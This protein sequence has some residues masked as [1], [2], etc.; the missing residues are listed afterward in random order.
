QVTPTWFSDHRLLTVSFGVEDPRFQAG[1][2]KLNKQ[3]LHEERYRRKIEA[4]LKNLEKRRELFSSA[5]HWWESC[6]Q[7]LAMVTRRYCWIRR[8]L[9]E[10]QCAQLQ[11]ELEALYEQLNQGGA[12]NGEK[13]A[14]VRSLLREKWLQRAKNFLFRLRGVWKEGEEQCSPQFFS[15]ERKQQERCCFESIRREDGTAVTDLPGML[16]CATGFYT[17]LFQEKEID[18]SIKERLLEGVEKAVDDPA[19]L[20]GPVTGAEIKTAL[21]GLKK[22]TV[23]GVDG[24]PAEFY[25]TF[26]DQLEPFLVQVF[27]EALDSNELINSFV[28]IPG[29]VLVVDGQIGRDSLRLIN[30]YAP[31]QRRLRKDFFTVLEPLLMTNKKIILGDWWED[32]KRRLK[33]ETIRYCRRRRKKKRL[34]NFSF[35]CSEGNLSCLFKMVRKDQK[36]MVFDGIQRKDGGVTMGAREMVEEAT[37][38]YKEFFREEPVSALLYVIYLEPLLEMI[39]KH[40]EINGI[41]IP[42]S[43]G[44]QAKLA[45]YA[46]D[47]VLMLD[48]D[49]GLLRAIEACNSFGQVT[50]AKI[51]TTKSKMKYFGIWKTRKETIGGLT[52]VPGP[53]KILGVNFAIRGSGHLNWKE[54][55]NFLKIKLGRWKNVQLSYSSKIMVVKSD[56]LSAL[57]FLAYVFPLPPSLRKEVIRSVFTF[58]W[59]NKNEYIRRVDMYRKIEEGGRDVPNIPLKLDAI[60]VSCLCRALKTDVMHKSQYF[61]RLWFSWTMPRLR[62]ISNTGPKADVTPWY[63]NH[64][65]KWL[66]NHPEGKD[67]IFVIQQ[68]ALY[69]LVNEQPGMAL[70]GK[71]KENW[72]RVQPKELDYSYKD[73]N[74]L[75][76]WNRLPVREVMFRHKLTKTKHCPYSECEETETIKHVF[77]ECVTAKQVWDKCQQFL[78]CIQPGFL[79]TSEKVTFAWK[80]TERKGTVDWVLWLVISIIKHFL[81]SA[82]CA[83]IR[84]GMK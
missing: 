73:L 15:A 19:S 80:G 27:N 12:F 79:L 60:F 72:I 31:A 26:W 24:L 18:A 58:I 1:Y 61:V 66:K 45:A 25:R 74:W 70:I 49:M 84:D 46:D 39:R 9:E 16:E 7:T 4:A 77:W 10:R 35:D 23:P 36:K 57:V 34:K 52:L 38:F 68:K 76:V 78:T 65:G 75:C 67:E 71:K 28:V 29:R 48:S 13:I 6:K 83:Q 32:V 3:V 40:K 53:I 81:W 82:R 37:K 55:I 50:G 56:G 30:V 51:N 59:S 47:V 43:R 17:A 69:N 8:S 14:N 33:R 21:F 63:Y 22:G 11:E 42:G 5:V 41:M 54:K 44:Q 2:W 20:V 64:A 62:P